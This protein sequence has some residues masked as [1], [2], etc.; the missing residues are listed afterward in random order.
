MNPKELEVYDNYPKLLS[1]MVQWASH[2]VRFPLEDMRS[3]AQRMGLSHAFI[4]PTGS[5]H[6]DPQVLQDHQ[7]LIELIMSFR[8]QYIELA[9]RTQRSS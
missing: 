5:Q 3:A 6:V 8:D 7:D 2:S 9:L 1:S 4:G